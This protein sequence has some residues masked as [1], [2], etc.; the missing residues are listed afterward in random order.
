MEVGV[1]ADSFIIFGRG[2]EYHDRVNRL[3]ALESVSLYSSR[4]KQQQL[5]VRFIVAK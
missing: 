4:A 1:G 3:I 5:A 2:I